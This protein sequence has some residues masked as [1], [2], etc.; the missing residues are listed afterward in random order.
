MYKLFQF[1]IV[2]C[3]LWGAGIIILGSYYYICDLIDRFKK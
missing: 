2:V 3:A 1:V